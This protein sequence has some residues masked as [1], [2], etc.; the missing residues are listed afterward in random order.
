MALKRF[1]VSLLISLLVCL[2]AF[3]QTPQ[4]TQSQKEQKELEKKALALLDDLVTEAMALRLV[5]NRIYVLTTA[6]NLLWKRNETR[7]RAWLR[8][9]VSQF[10]AMEQPADPDNPQ[11]FVA[12]QLRME[13][14][15]QLLQSLASRDA[16]LALEFL[17]ASRMPDARKLL[18]SK[19]VTP[20][21]EQQFEMQLASRIAENDPQM[22]LQIAE[23]SLKEGLNYQVIEIWINLMNKDS[24]AAA[25]LSGEI[26]ARM[27]SSDLMKNYQSTQTALSMLNHLRSQIQ[28]AQR[29]AKDSS[30][31]SSSS[32]SLQASLPEMQ[33]AFRELLEIVVSAALKITTAQLL[34]VQEQGQARN[35]LTQVQMLLPEIEKHLPAR[36]PAVRAKLTQFDK[37]FYR[38]PMPPEPYEALE[39]KTADELI[40]LAAKSQPEI[41]DALYRQAIAKA[42]EQGDTARARQMAKDF[43]SHSGAADPL[44][45]E[46]E[47]AEREQA[48]KQG[49]LEEAH[50]SLARLGSDE[51]RALALIEMALKAEANKDQKSQRQ[52][53]AEARELLGDQMET[54]VQVEA[55][56]ALG[57]ASLNLDADR[58]FAGLE[59]AI[60]RLNVVLSAV[61]TLARFDQG[62]WP[63]GAGGKDGEMRLN[64]GEFGNVTTN[65]EQ[66][67]MAFARKDFDRTVA[68]LK[69]W[70]VNEVR[71]AM[72]LAL[73]NGILGDEKETRF[74]SVFGEKLILDQ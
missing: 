67:I 52:L 42:M 17:R 65:L 62:G 10:L 9:A 2:P 70:Q 20:D 6:A 51:E 19:G 27:R 69:R 25:K 72:N 49:K 5:E 64:A 57:I 32:Q 36:A 26:I 11:S 74:R 68:L 12:L 46:I 66:Q 13:L 45:A 53:L 47:R 24:K 56:L 50:Q 48:V 73:V 37:A 41:K 15:N 4:P 23:E 33:Q 18:G 31:Q 3:A 22:A 59:S 55:Q 61:M 35:L 21:F 29:S 71:L 54:R 40:A 63:Y 38:P 34:D 43:L 16:Q 8:E 58:S 60:E 44:M 1:T 7:A 39:K 30:P 14:R 28:A